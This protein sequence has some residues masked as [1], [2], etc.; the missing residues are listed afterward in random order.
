MVIRGA[1]PVGGAPLGQSVQALRTPE[2]GLER[3]TPH[4]VGPFIFAQNLSEIFM[5]R[6]T[7]ALHGPQLSVGPPNWAEYVPRQGGVL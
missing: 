5:Y 4:G 1:P 2:E 6:L 3:P 7:Q